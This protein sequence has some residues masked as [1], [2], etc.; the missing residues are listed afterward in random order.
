MDWHADLAEEA[1]MADITRGAEVV[2]NGS[3]IHGDGSLSLRTGILSSVPVS[4]P[5]RTE[6]PAGK[7]SPEELIAGAHA[8]CYAMA[9]ANELA[10]GGHPAESLRVSAEVTA[11]LSTGGLRITKSALTVRG[12]VPGLGASDFT[13]WAHKGEEACPVS[14]ALR[15]NVEITVDAA[16]E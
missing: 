1:T 7:T 15:G 13:E 2:W 6:G 4:W 11:N 3:L 14:N 16:I 12:R 10:Q 5:A 8:T 9:L